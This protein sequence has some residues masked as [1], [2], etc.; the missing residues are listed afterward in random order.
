MSDARDSRWFLEQV[1]REQ[2]RLRAYV[3]SLG[4]RAEAVD[5]LSQ[6]A[7]VVAFE[8][9]ETFDAAGGDFG[10]WVR[11]IARRLAANAVRK[12]SR[13]RQFLSG[14]LTELLLSA[15]EKQLHPLAREGD[16][17]LL[18]ALAKCL[19][20]LPARN[21]QVVHLRY[22]EQLTPGTI[23][24]HL[25]RTA[26]DVRQSLFR[27]RRALLGCIEGRLKSAGA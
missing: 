20:K 7:L 13:R 27:I 1:Q 18:A 8:K 22:F 24:S 25:E 4:V 9:R 12:E 21:R 15:E 2:S 6:D 11:G 17:D 10:G 3:R 26:N 14:H 16:P 19:E 23:A 5:D